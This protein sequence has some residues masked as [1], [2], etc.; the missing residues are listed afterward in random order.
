MTQGH[1]VCKT[2]VSSE[3]A[4]ITTNN[5]VFIRFGRRS[6]SGF[7]EPTA[8]NA[9]VCGYDIRR[10]LDRVRENLGLC[11]QH[12]VLFDTLTVEEHLYFFGSVCSFLN[13]VSLMTYQFA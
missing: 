7:L 8:G 1:R 4:D 10:N 3:A 2:S 5:I 11:P 9:V 13:D 12:D 6:V